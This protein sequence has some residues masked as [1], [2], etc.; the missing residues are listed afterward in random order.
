M[1]AG[2]RRIYFGS[3]LN[4]SHFAGKWVVRALGAL[5]YPEP[6]GFDF[7]HVLFLVVFI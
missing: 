6:L 5:I 1:E 7:K 2:L 3:M 4:C